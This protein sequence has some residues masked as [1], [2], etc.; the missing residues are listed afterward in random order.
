[1]FRQFA[2][3]EIINVAVVVTGFTIVCCILLYTFVKA[4]MKQ[5][6]IRYEADLADTILRSMRHA[7]IRTDRGSLQEI[8]SDIGELKRVEYV[9]VFKCTGVISFSDNLEEINNRFAGESRVCV[10]CHM[11]GNPAP[12]LDTMDKA[13]T[14]TNRHGL[15]IMSIVTPIRNEPGCLVGDCHALQAEKPL[16][17]VMDIGLSQEHMDRSLARLRLRMVIFCV[18]ILILTVA[19]VTALLWRGVMQPLGELVDF[20]SQCY[21]GKHED[22]PPMGAS[23]INHIGEILRKLAADRSVPRAEAEDEDDPS[24]G[25]LEGG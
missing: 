19:G 22:D 5:D 23:E 7:M 21:E 16:L 4:D 9:R 24:S 15:R 6:S 18:M 17:G 25:D 2:T 13:S 12:G 14:Y 3:R 8:I 1:M 10:K 11:N 20:A